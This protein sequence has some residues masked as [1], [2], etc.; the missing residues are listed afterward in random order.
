[1]PGVETSQSII[2]QGPNKETPKRHSH[3]AGGLAQSAFDEEIIEAP[4]V[5]L[6]LKIPQMVEDQDE[7]G[8]PR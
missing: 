7:R 4:T 1:M 2:T 5:H 3:L 6:I 8:M